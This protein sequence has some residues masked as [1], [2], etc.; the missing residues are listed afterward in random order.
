MM[1]IFVNSIRFERKR[2]L[3]QFSKRLTRSI[4]IELESVFYVFF[5]KTRNS[6]QS[7]VDFDSDFG[8]RSNNEVG[9]SGDREREIVNMISTMMASR[10]RSRRLL[11]VRRRRSR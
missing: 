10:R 1:M 6:S 4:G 5:F 7:T 2:R 8:E 9:S 3:I 11:N